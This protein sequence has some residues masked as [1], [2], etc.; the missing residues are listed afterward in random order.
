MKLFQYL[1]TDFHCYSEVR[2][3][4][5]YLLTEEHS[6][7]FCQDQYFYITIRRIDSEEPQPSIVIL[8][9]NPVQ[10]IQTTNVLHESHPE[11]GSIQ[12]IEK[13]KPFGWCE[14]L[15]NVERKPIMN[16][17][18]EDAQNR[19]TFC[20]T[21]TFWKV[22]QEFTKHWMKATG[23]RRYGLWDAPL[24][25]RS[26]SIIPGGVGIDVSGAVRCV[27]LDFIGEETPKET[28]DNHNAD[29]QR[30]L[31]AFWW[32]SAKLVG[33]CFQEFCCECYAGQGTRTATIESRVERASELTLNSVSL[34]HQ[35]PRVPKAK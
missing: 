31:W 35:T 7:L 26:V 33:T 27:I 30:V 23:L 28:S 13:L 6:V 32:P 2:R 22:V 8:C 4:C 29:Y 9:N 20:V 10:P 25:Q 5:C 24:F 3:R 15:C 19:D 14:A 12:K 21:A 16:R 17:S 1:F 18:K 34:K 11:T